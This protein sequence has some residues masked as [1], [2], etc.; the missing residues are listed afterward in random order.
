VSRPRA[1]HAASRKK[2]EEGRVAT[3]LRRYGAGSR[4][5]S[6]RG[7]HRRA[8]RARARAKVGRFCGFFAAWLEKAPGEQPADHATPPLGVS[9]RARA[10]GR[11]DGGS[12]RPAWP[13]RDLGGPGDRPDGFARV[14]DWP[15]DDADWGAAHGGIARSYRRGRN[16]FDRADADPS[17][18]NLHELRKRVKD[19]W[20]HERLLKGAWPSVIGTQADEAHAL[21]DLLGDDHDLAVL[22]ERLWS[23]PS[24]DDTEAILELI[25]QR[26]GELLA[27]IRPLARRVYAEKPKRFA[28]RLERYMRSAETA[29]AVLG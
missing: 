23:E 28:G 2:Q 25:E 6:A 24:T 22:A 5:I 12:R 9:A 14:D 26:R 1:L 18:E 17:T 7:P 16:A 8:R 21:S 4:P 15:L 13:G 11:G 10:A 20:Y 3:P 27:R 19:L 29:D